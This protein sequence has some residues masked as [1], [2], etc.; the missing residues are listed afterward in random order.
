MRDP[1]IRYYHFDEVNGQ[2]LTDLR[3]PR[4]QEL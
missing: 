4:V 1:S 2:A 3:T